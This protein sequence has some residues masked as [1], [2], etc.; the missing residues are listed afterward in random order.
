MLCKTPCFYFFL[1]MA[2]SVSTTFAQSPR[3]TIN[4][5]HLNSKLVEEL[6]LKELNQLRNSKG[7]STLVTDN[8]LMKAADD[9]A[10]YC[11]KQN[12]VT[13]FQKGVQHK[14]DVKERVHYYNGNH[15]MV[16]ENVLMSFI[17]Q[18]FTDSHTQQQVTVYTYQQL[19]HQLFEAWK[20]SP[21]HYRNM[22][23]A[24]Y[25]N[26]ALSLALMDN[27]T[28]L[29]AVE[30]FASEPYLPPKNSLHYTDSTYGIK[31]QE[32]GLCKGFGTHDFLAQV[33][34]SYLL[35]EGDSVFQYYQE[36]KTIHEM[37]TGPK[38]GIALDIMYKDQFHCDLPNHLH[39]STVFDGYLL[40]PHYRD[41]LF[42]N[43][44]Y[45]N[46]EFLSFV[47]KIPANAPRKDLQVNTILI[48]NGMACR[49]SFPVTLEQGILPD[50]AIDPMWCKTKGVIKKD[51]AN[52][53]K[54]F[55]I[56]F[57][58][59]D[60]TT[61]SFYFEKLSRLVK[62]FDGA[63]SKIEIT[64]YSSV[65]GTEANN[66]ELQTARSS[67]IENFI[68][69]R[70]HQQTTITKKAIENWDLFHKQIQDTPYESEFA[71]SA[72]E[73]VRAKINQRMD[74][75][76]FRYWLD[77]ERVASITLHVNKDFDDSITSNFLPL[78]LYNGLAKGDTTQA[79]VAFSRMI[80]AYQRGEI[81]KYFLT[82]I[83][84][85]LESKNLPL[86]SNYLAS[87][88]EEGDVFNYQHF[89]PRYY[90][91]ID[92][93][94][95]MFHDF[96]PLTF[97]LAVYKTHLYFRGMEDNVDAF[98]KIEDEIA[99]FKKDT[100]FEKELCDHLFY[101]YYLTASIFYK[102]KRL[103][104]DMYIAFEKVKPYLSL[105]SLKAEEVYA[106][107]K[108]F[109]YFFRFNETIELLEKYQKKYPEDEDLTFLYI[110]AGSVYNLNINYHLDEYYRQID[111]LAVMN[112]P[113]L[114]E[115]FN[116][117]YQL[118]REETFKKKI[119]GYCSLKY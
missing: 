86:I 21:G 93:A 76:V 61:D 100:S 102:K 113:R 11:R 77:Q 23:T 26:T 75:P 105:A 68:F 52:F 92:S 13:H 30:V 79:R 35:R 91:Y 81:D 88:L 28:V 31:E 44:V 89:N 116:D 70:L 39:P 117:N 94:K 46:S 53:T 7:L 96:K 107:G 18:R 62:I 56:P 66:L 71:D 58:K 41:E 110:S 12:E 63:I 27:K 73:N 104:S 42:K 115:W 55:F 83:E 47:G 59:N 98:K 40:P 54:Q 29:Y 95:K 101:N 78:A 103:Y 48:Q 90:A 8:T 72:I 3:D 22:I 118:L 9:Q 34:S 16:G 99:H 20:N 82:A 60:K 37:L 112:R 38:D 119:C 50:L 25:S 19:A 97:N 65:E 10:A 106:V 84:V 85:P 64:A 109:N 1:L 111:K 36:E 33:F 5:D 15:N 45:K 32:P 43:D 49:Y 74:E 4:R 2:L 24:S 14:Y 69:K 80:T 87:V 108:Y 51:N 114:C 57:Q 6:F 67:F 17:F